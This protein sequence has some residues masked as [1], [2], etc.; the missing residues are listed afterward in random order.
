VKIRA[1]RQRAGRA[2]AVASALLQTVAGFQ[3]AIAVAWLGLLFSDHAHALSSMSDGR[4]L[5]FVLTHDDSRDEHGHGSD[6]HLHG[7]PA[8]DHVFH[9]ASDDVRDS[10]RAPPPGLPVAVDASHPALPTSRVGGGLAP[11]F[12]RP[13]PPLW[14]RSVVLRT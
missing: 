10:R 3:L 6:T 7:S 9:L 14:R 5:D 4:H 12:E 1:K 8:D 11:P 2:L 13:V